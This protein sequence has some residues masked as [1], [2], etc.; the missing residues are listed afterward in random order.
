MREDA[1]ARQSTDEGVGA[2][3]TCTRR[4]LRISSATTNRSRLD[5]PVKT[6]ALRMSTESTTTQILSHFPAACC[7]TLLNTLGLPSTCA[8]GSTA[9]VMSI[10]GA[11]MHTAMACND[12]KT[13]G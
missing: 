3:G 10:K 1:I 4:T 6:V 13:E 8:M 7:A 5:S 9:N 2:D 11:L 12:R